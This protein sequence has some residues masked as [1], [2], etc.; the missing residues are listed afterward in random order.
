MP[1][2]YESCSAMLLDHRAHGSQGHDKESGFRDNGMRKRVNRWWKPKK[3][4]FLVSIC[5]F[6]FV[7]EQSPQFG[8]LAYC[9]AVLTFMFSIFKF[10][11]NYYHIV[12]KYL[13]N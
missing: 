5:A 11:L 13:F 9:L 1:K 3:S 7:N 8:I 4:Y 2:C 12:V 6:R 10:S